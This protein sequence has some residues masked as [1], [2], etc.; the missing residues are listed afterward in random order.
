MKH[1]PFVSILF[2][3]L[4]ASLFSLSAC[5]GADGT[6]D[7]E[8]D[9][10]QVGDNSMS[11]DMTG[12]LDMGPGAD[13][14]PDGPDMPGP[15]VLDMSGPIDQGGPN[16]PDMSPDLDMPP[17]P[18]LPPPVPDMETI[19]DT[20]PDMPPA[21]DMAPPLAL[22]DEL[23]TAP[24]YAV[25]PVTVNMAG[26][27]GFMAELTFNADGTVRLDANGNRDGKWEILPGLGE[28]VRL[29]DLAQ[30][31]PND[32]NELV[33]IPVRSRQGDLVGLDL[34]TGAASTIVFEQV[35]L[36]SSRQYTLSQLVG[37]WRSVDPLPGQNPNEDLRLAL[38]I[39]NTQIEYGVLD[40]A[41]NYQGFLLKLA[42]TA[43]FVDGSF[44]YMIPDGGQTMGPS[45][46][47][48]IAVVDGITTIYALYSD[49]NNNVQYS[50]PLQRMAPS[51]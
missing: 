29:Y 19:E 49:D 23:Q 32:P 35:T 14:A 7:G 46:A 13:S 43:D 37:T 27:V 40:Q 44:W 4:L 42:S 34:I 36:R 11:Q 25:I 48:E 10:W 31:S 1:R 15:P 18:D 17:E 3:M 33:L 47:G 2:A 26:K 22:E 51:P 16:E 45:L 50:L 20:P 21:S 5:S 8:T 41:G 9:P 24:W 30:P 28:R 12:G 39:D 6:P 38:R